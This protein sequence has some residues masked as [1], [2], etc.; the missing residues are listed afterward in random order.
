MV[1]FASFGFMMPQQ[2]ASSQGQQQQAS[3]APHSSPM[4]GGYPPYGQGSN[5]FGSTPVF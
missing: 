5:S 1:C 3:G 4:R 2:Q